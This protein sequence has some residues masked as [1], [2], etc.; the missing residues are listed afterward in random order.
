M[1]ANNTFDHV[2]RVLSSEIL[3]TA[4]CTPCKVASV[5]GMGHGACRSMGPDRGPLFGQFSH[6]WEA[7][8]G[9]YKRWKSDGTRHGAAFIEQNPLH[10]GPAFH[11]G[12]QNSAHG[13]LVNVVFGDA[14]VEFIDGGDE[15]TMKSIGV[16][17]DSENQ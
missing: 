8:E 4:C 7:A 3:F 2:G 17:D 1:R 11:I 12:L 5:A 13:N 10:S 15:V 9:L 6:S 14:H 16:P